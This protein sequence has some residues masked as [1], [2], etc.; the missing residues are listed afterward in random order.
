MRHALIGIC[1]HAF[2]RAFANS[3]ANL[4]QH[5][6]G[7]APKEDAV[8]DPGFAEEIDDDEVRQVSYNV[9]RRTAICSTH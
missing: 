4:P 2:C 1:D 5:N 9:H 7:E 6:Y 8:F 3:H